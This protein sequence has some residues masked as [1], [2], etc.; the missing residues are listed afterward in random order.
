[1]NNPC[2]ECI[3]RIMCDDA[4][5][6]FVSY[7]ISHRWIKKEMDVIIKNYPINYEGLA[8]YIKTGIGQDV[9]IYSPIFNL[10]KRVIEK[11]LTIVMENPK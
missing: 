10:K 8:C 6:K 5:D 1:M 2:E 4:C 3:V 9:L 7:L 11:K